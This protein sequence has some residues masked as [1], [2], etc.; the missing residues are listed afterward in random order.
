LK[1][2]KG[3]FGLMAIKIDI[4][5]AFDHMEW[6]FVFDILAKLGF[7]PTWINWIR[8]CITSPSFSILINDSP[9]RLFTPTG[10][11]WQGDPLSP[12]LIL[13]IEVFSRLLQWQSSLSLLKGIKMAWTCYP[14]THLLFADDLL[15]FAKATSSEAS[16]IKFCLDSYCN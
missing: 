6:N 4:E 7:H 5:K 14:I 8:I 16:T 15:I 11:L 13:G 12:F 1:A 10:G 2:K 3:K 9:F